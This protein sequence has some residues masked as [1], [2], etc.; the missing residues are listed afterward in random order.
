MW[1]VRLDGIRVT[2]TKWQE[3][4]LIRTEYINS[5]D[6]QDVIRKSYQNHVEGYDANKPLQR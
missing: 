6:T 1:F 4:T 3:D 2:L 5:T